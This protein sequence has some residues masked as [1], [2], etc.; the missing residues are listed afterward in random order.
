MKFIPKTSLIKQAF[1]ALVANEFRGA[2]FEPDA[3]GKGMT[4]GQQ[5]GL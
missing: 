2:T 1:E 4:D 3:Q 5:V